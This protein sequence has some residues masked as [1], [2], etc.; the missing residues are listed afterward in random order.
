MTTEAS[1][2]QETGTPASW[3]RS[4]KMLVL[5]GLLVL[6]TVLVVLVVAVMLGVIPKP[7]LRAV[8]P[9]AQ[10]LS[11]R[12]ASAYQVLAQ[13]VVKPVVE[14]KKIVSD[15]DLMPA[16][17]RVVS[18]AKAE[19]LRRGKDFAAAIPLFGQLLTNAKPNPDNE[20][21]CDYFSLRIA[22]CRIGLSQIDQAKAQLANLDASAS[23]IIRAVSSF[24]QA[25]LDLA[26]GKY[27]DARKYA[28]RSIAAMG[29]MERPLPLQSDCHFLIARALTSKVRSLK[30]VDRFIRWPGNLTKDP[31]A[32]LGK[33]ELRGIL[34]EGKG[35]MNPAALGPELKISKVPNQP[36]RWAITASHVSAGEVLNQF[37]DKAGLEITWVNVD[38]KV[39]RRPISLHFRAISPQ[40]LNEVSAGMVGLISRF[41]LN[42]TLVH[43]PM[44][45]ATISTQRDMLIR[46]AVSAWRLFFLRYPRDARNPEGHF[47]LAAIRQWSGDDVAADREYQILARRFERSKVAPLALLRCAKIKMSMM[48]YPG[49]RKDMMDLLDLYPDHPGVAEVY[50]LLGES[51]EAAG[52]IARAAKAHEN[53]SHRNLSA[54]SRA[55]AALRAGRCHFRLKDYKKA[56]KWLARYVAMLD[57]PNPREY[58]EAYFMLGKSEASRGNLKVATQAYRRGFLGRPG[59]KVRIPAICELTRLYIQQENFV[60][61]IKVLSLLSREKLSAPQSCRKAILA[62]EIYRS[63]GLVDKARSI[64]RLELGAVG[65]KTLRS[66]IGIG[67]AKCHIASGDHVSARNLL[68]EILPNLRPGPDLWNA[69]LQLANVCVK[70]NQPDQAISVL[71]PILK[72]QCS[73]EIRR[74]ITN[75]L[76]EAYLL[77]KQYNKAAL[78]FADIKDQDKTPTVTNDARANAEQ[79]GENK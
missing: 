17:P 32:G 58:V 23:P 67:L 56:S 27:L 60:E 48:N 71:K 45:L 33:A 34:A 74:Q 39:R 46:E 16:R 13:P 12:Q 62:A 47:A 78:A 18:W 21:V 3:H 7:T 15:S 40:K 9:L 66:K 73:S 29:A 44:R 43:D 57:E 69:S 64:L 10:S 25:R 76:G 49:A 2:K 6:N 8:E 65:D 30:T 19:K 53:L 11:P 14:D 41:T 5:Q 4:K 1:E 72:S 28:Y 79:T 59:A 68:M 24:E 61:A 52:Q 38:P 26:E 35:L 77:K 54:S 63:M 70:F 75:A 55:E 42:K 37:C 20:L 50:L 22:Q 31:F 51:L 36:G